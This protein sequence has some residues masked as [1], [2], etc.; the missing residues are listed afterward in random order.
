[1]TF[2]MS[3][4]TGQTLLD[5]CR[6]ETPTVP[7]SHMVRDTTPGPRIDSPGGLEVHH[8]SHNVQGMRACVREI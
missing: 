5:M 6:R 7:D 2:M 8:E 1:V 4:P 3:I